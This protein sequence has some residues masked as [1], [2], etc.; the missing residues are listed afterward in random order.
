MIGFIGLSH[1]GLNYS[2][3]TA[4]KGFDVVAYDPDKALAACCARGEFPIEEPGFKELFAANRAR[5][6][7]TADAGDLAHCDLIFYALDIRTNERNESDTGPLTRL[8]HDTAPAIA[9]NS[10]IVLLSQVSPGF[11]RQLIAEL[12]KRPEVNVRFIYYQVE[13]LIFGAAVHRAMEPERYIVGAPDSTAPLSPALARWHGAFNCPVLVMRLESA[14]LTKIAI[15][16]FLVS[17]VS[18]T[19][20]LAELCEKSGADW[21]EIA[22]A[23]RL[24][25][26]IGPHA[27]LTPGLGISGG[28]LERDL[29]T[30]QALASL[31]GTD[32]GVVR[33]W[34]N[35]SQHRAHWALR[36]LH[37]EVLPRCSHPR[38]AVWGLTYKADT[39]SLKNS[40]AIDLISA[41]APFEITAFDPVATDNSIHTANLKLARTALAA[42]H[43]ADVL[44]VMTPWKEFSQIDPLMI[45]AE[46]SGRVI[47]DP[48]G[49]ITAPGFTHLQLG[50]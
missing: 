18:T 17:S 24:D 14:E 38:I 21:S 35:N 2:L 11:T 25:R 42:C 8:I 22:P 16:C 29:V 13:T 26:R 32:A 1:L 4:A 41:L 28:N 37:R 36:Q 15:N 40:P 33:A 3:A 10:T 50:Q 47:I 7:Y 48:F 9:S 27:Y 44:V 49:I 12:T 34:Q 30:V 6:R 43:K 5:L 20:T 23:L 31:H 19:N 39:H 46:M 45:Q